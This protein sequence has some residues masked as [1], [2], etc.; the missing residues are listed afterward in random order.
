MPLILKVLVLLIAAVFLF[1]GLVGMFQPAQLAETF[2]FELPTP[3]SV[4]QMRAM[5]GAHY[6]AMGSV[7]LFAGLRNL[8]TLLLPIGVIE[9]TM[10]LARLVA[11]INGEFTSAIIAPI[12]IEVAA[13]GILLTAARRS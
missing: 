5:I 3:E 11:A 12:A 9:A 1:I 6:L 8:P 13:C 2:G 4:G 10:L 7:C